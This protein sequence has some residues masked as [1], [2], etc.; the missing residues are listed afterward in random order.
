MDVLVA[1]AASF[2]G[3][4]LAYRLPG[5]GDRV[6]GI[7]NL[8]SY[9][10]VSLKE[11]RCDRLAAAGGEHVTFIR[12]DFADRAGLDAAL[13]ECEFDTIVHLGA[14][15]SVRYSIEH[16]HVYA[17]SNLVGHLNLL[18]FAR[19]RNVQHMVYASSS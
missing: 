1:G 16:P 5:R 13:A 6:I 10:P 7:D 3:A 18:E 9:Y 12:Q 8:N 4:A 17:H 11:D 15:P 2:I 14:Q 19:H